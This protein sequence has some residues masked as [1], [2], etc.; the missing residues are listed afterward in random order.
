[1][2]DRSRSRTTIGSISDV[3]ADTIQGRFGARS[4]PITYEDRIDI[5]RPTGYDSWP[6][7]SR[8]GPDSDNIRTSEDGTSKDLL[9]TRFGRIIGRQT[10]GQIRTRIVSVLGPTSGP[11]RARH[12]VRFGPDIGSVSG[13]IRTIFVRP[14]MVP[15]R[16]GLGPD[17]DVKSDVRQTRHRARFG[18]ESDQ[19]SCWGRV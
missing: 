15:L 9:R 3:Q 17:S 8:I 13:P 16:T 11:F 10:S 19:M 5:G 2:P 14:K 1:M 18:H 7:L 12:R 6:I 4:E